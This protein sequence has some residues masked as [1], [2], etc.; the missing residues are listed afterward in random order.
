MC[1][2]II[3]LHFYHKFKI[4]QS[5]RPSLILIVAVFMSWWSFFYLLSLPLPVTHFFHK[6]KKCIVKTQNTLLYSLFEKKKLVLFYRCSLVLLLLSVRQS[7]SFVVVSRS[8]VA[9]VNAFDFD[10]NVTLLVWLKGLN[11]QNIVQIIKD[12]TEKCICLKAEEKWAM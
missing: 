12:K 1:V 6:V 2:A 3:I 10:T 5:T 11:E 9:V 7:V 8:S 4:S